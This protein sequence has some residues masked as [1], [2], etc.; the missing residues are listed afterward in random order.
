MEKRGD[1]TTLNMPILSALYVHLNLT[2][3]Y[4]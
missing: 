4:L 2:D 1:I 3:L